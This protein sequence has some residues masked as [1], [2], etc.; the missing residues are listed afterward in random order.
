MN[1]RKYPARMFVIGLIGNFLL[2]YFYL[3]LPGIILCVIGIW[4]K[5]CLCIGLAML[6]LDLIFSVTDQ[7]KIR[8][9]CL[10]TSDNPE[11]N[12]LMD[13]FYGAAD[14]ESIH[15]FI[16]EK[17]QSSSSDDEDQISE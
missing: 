6:I 4:S 7:I 1:N 13:I 15:D 2:H 3:F 16:K 10:S 5:V 12:R 11:V 14:P 17:M 8:N 9:A